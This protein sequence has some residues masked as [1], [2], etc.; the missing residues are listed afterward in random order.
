M[1]PLRTL[2]LMDL[3][4]QT[5]HCKETICHAQAY[6]YQNVELATKKSVL[7]SSVVYLITLMKNQIM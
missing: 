3:E 1:E 6:L 4:P 7:S 2:R 5:G